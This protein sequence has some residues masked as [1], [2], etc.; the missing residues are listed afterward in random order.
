LRVKIMPLYDSLEHSP[1]VIAQPSGETLVL[2]HMNSGKYFSLNELGA[3]IWELCDGG[4]TFSEIV[5]LVEAE[6]DA[7]QDVILEDSRSLVAHLIEND[8]LVEK[9]AGHA[10]SG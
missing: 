7:P 9:I 5:G 1:D 8:L 2:F 4:R 10:I 3:R 6:Y